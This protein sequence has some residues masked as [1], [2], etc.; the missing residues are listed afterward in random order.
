[1]LS[2]NLIYFLLG[3]I[4]LVHT[5]IL[6]KL[7]YFPYPELFIYPYLTNHGLKPYSQILDQHF[8]GLMFLP[9]N[10]NNLGITTPEIARVWS[11]VIVLLVQ[12]MLFLIGREILKSNTKAILINILY[13]VWQ[14]F[15]EGWVLWIDN[16][17]PLMLLPAFYLLYR[18]NQWFFCSGLFLGLGIVFKQTI[19]PL[20]VFVLIYIFWKT[21][22]LKSCLRFLLGLFIPVVLTVVYLSS[23][24]VLGDFW[25]WTIIFNLTTYVKEGRGGGPTLAHFSRV[26]LVFGSAFLVIL[27]IKSK[28]AQILL[29]F[30]IGALLGLSTR[31]DFVHFQPALPFAVL[32]TIYGLG[33]SGGWGR[34]GI[35]IGYLGVSL[36]WLNIFYK[37]HLGDRVI[38]FDSSTRELAVKI[39]KFTNPGEKIFVYGAQPHLYQMSDTLPAGDVFVFQFPW[40]L[41]IA[42]GRILEGIKADKPNIIVSDRTVIIE[43]AKIIDFAFDVDQYIRENYQKIDSAGSADILQ[44]KSSI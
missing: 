6:T 25:Y 9:V 34:L 24:G 20:S 3:I 40:F 1:M 15:F 2:R 10:L 12:I 5:V 21:R 7:I 19:I 30:L 28:E 38:S 37:G 32:A 31:F 39:K 16:F 33:K 11:I 18:R 4:L 35:A 26:L 42:E 23:I 36:W 29:I 17:L 22:R 43:E 13:L 41:K 8:P 27:R 44:R 14:P